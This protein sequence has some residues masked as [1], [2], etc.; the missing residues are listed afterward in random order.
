MA[1][2]LLVAEL[3][4]RIDVET[5]AALF[6]R[7]M[8]ADVPIPDSDEIRRRFD[9]MLRAVPNELGDVPSDRTELL[10]EAYGL[11]AGG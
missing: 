11:T 1:Y 5:Q 9:E 3:D 6:A 2:V 7:A 10:R 4:R 8:G